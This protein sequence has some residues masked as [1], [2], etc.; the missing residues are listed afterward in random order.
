MSSFFFY[1]DGV[2]INYKRT[3]FF[4]VLQYCDMIG[5][6]L[7]RFCYHDQLS[8]SGNC[9]MCVIETSVSVKPVIACATELTEGIY[10][11]TSSFLAITARENVL[12]FLL[13]SHPLDCP[14]C[15]Q[16]GECD[17]Q[18]LSMLFGSDT[19][20]FFYCKRSVSDK[21]LGFFVKCVMDRCIHCTRCVR[22]MDEL[23]GVPCL[24]TIGRGHETEL[25]TFLDFDYVDSVVLGNIID[26]CPVGALTSKPYAFSAR[27][28]E[29]T[30]TESIDILD[31]LCSNIRI[32]YRGLNIM[33]I[34]PRLNTLVNEEWITD[35]IRFCY[36]GV[37][38]NRLVTPF[39][40]SVTHTFLFSCS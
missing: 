3:H 40:R 13:I 25:S 24:G 39:V 22:F 5:V 30:S 31:S 19:S 12:G 29:L 28:W 36:D 35:K 26:L 1:I 34:L 32:D 23:V 33:R 7:P 18:D 38:N 6:E 15:D 17:L 20:S 9:R 8:I 37:S 2:K 14:I 4:T 27:P 11:Y 21:V 16:G 10:I